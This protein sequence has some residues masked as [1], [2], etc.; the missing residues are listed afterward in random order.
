MHQSKF[1]HISSLVFFFVTLLAHGVTT[2]IQAQTDTVRQVV[3]SGQVEA[4]YQYDFGKP[5]AHTRPDFI[6]NHKRVNEVNINL[7]YLKAAFMQGRTR[8]NLAMMIGNYAEYNLAAESSIGRTIY[9]ANVGIK[10]SQKRA[11]WL[12][13][14]V[15]PAHIGFE[16]AIS[17]DCPTV[18][19]SLVAENS[20]YFETGLK[21]SYTNK[22]EKWR[23]AALLLNG[24]QRINRADGNQNPS[25]GL[26]CTY[27]PNTNW[28]INYS[29]FIGSDEPD[30]DA[31]LRVYHNFYALYNRDDRWFLT[32]GF[33]HGTD[34]NEA[35]KRDQWFTPVFIVRNKWNAKWAAA[36]RGE[37]F[38]DRSEVYLKPTDS[39]GFRV[40]GWSCNLDYAPFSNALCRLEARFFNSNEA[41]Q[42]GGDLEKNTNLALLFSTSVRF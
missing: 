29:N 39:N 27:V 3:I 42:W 21:L 19:R 15:M 41:I 12:D 32:L 36:I 6:Y 13:M 10:L 37:Y 20:P 31:D 35:D 23:M 18:S 38:Q 33:D 30:S 26:Q 40:S 16:S 4:Y 1:R 7:A 17:A 5:I 24:W 11:L 28:L 14:G 2:E 25:F 8:A 34:T 9:E 22:S